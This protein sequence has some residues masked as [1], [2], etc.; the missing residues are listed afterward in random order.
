MSD[1][2]IITICIV[3]ELLTIDSD[4][5]W[6]GFCKKNMRDLFPKSV[7]GPGSIEPA[8]TCTQ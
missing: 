6:L 7:T 8:E 4:K 5:A 3:G 1:S 2:E